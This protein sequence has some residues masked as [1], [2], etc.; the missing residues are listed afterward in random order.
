MPSQQSD[1]S[2]LSV[3]YKEKIDGLRRG[4]RVHQAKSGR[5]QFVDQKNW[6]ITALSGRKGHFGGSGT[7]KGTHDERKE[8]NVAF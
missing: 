6:G 7:C 5:C 8:R 4:E 3:D 2:Y 1:W